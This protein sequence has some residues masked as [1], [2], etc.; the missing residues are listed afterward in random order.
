MEYWFNHT[1]SE[2]PTTASFELPHANTQK[3]NGNKNSCPTE[4]NQRRWRQ[5]YAMT[6]QK[7]CRGKQQGGRSYDE[8]D[9]FPPWQIQSPQHHMQNNETLI[10]TAAAASAV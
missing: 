7:L 9:S 2:I 4:R 3:S 5:H 6:Y 10:G 8:C 1:I